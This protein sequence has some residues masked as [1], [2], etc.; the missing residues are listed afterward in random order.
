M[1]LWV[2]RQKEE[3]NRKKKKYGKKESE[4]CERYCDKQIREEYKEKGL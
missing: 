1:L 2:S 3:L 4:R